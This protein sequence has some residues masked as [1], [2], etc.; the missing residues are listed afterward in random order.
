MNPAFYVP[1]CHKYIRKKDDAIDA[2]RIFSV[3]KTAC[4][5]WRPQTSFN[6]SELFSFL[7]ENQILPSHVLE[8]D[9]NTDEVELCFSIISQYKCNSIC[10]ICPY[11]PLYRNQFENEE[12][13]LL[14]YALSSWANLQLLTA[15]GLTCRHFRAMIPVSERSVVLVV[16]L[17]RLA[18]EYL[19]KV[20]RSPRDMADITD[21]IIATLQQN[22]KDKLSM[23]DLDISRRYLENLCCDKYQALSPEKLA[24]LLKKCFNLPLH[25]PENQTRPAV[26]SQ[27][28]PHPGKPATV[29]EGLLTG[30]NPAPARERTSPQE[31]AR[32][33]RGRI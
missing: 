5:T 28:T 27:T 32:N 25:L 18:F 14:G 12:A 16:P 23:A 24:I 26:P 8:N 10:Q 4:K 29:L 30:S 2:Q 9:I 20:P 17:N 21:K 22:N 7:K 19:E 31:M 13:L 15:N 11:S 1:A 3:S 6:D 33:S